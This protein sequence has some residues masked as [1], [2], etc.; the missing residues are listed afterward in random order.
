MV[1]APVRCRPGQHHPDRPDG[2]GTRGRRPAWA[3]HVMNKARCSTPAC[4]DRPVRAHQRRNSAIAC[5]YAFVVDSAPS[6]P[7]RCWRKKPSAT[8]TTCRSSS[9]TVQYRC[10]D[11]NLTGNAR[12]RLP[13][14]RGWVVHD[15]QPRAAH[16]RR[17]TAPPARSPGS[18]D[19]TQRAGKPRR[20]SRCPA[21]GRTAA[22]RADAHRRP[23]SSGPG[24]RS[25]R[26]GASGQP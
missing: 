11:G 7:N 20:T 16:P 19:V 2:P 13:R 5:A 15:Y 3:S 8:A 12:T 14:F 26:G 10:P 9:S 21:A 17:T 22:G 18:G 23:G 6:R 1:T 4:H 25:G 24:R